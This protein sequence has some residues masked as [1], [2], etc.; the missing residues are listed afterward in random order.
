MSTATPLEFNVFIAVWR[1]PFE[2]GPCAKIFTK[3][4]FSPLLNGGIGI[5][6][7]LSKV[8]LL[9]AICWIVLVAEGSIEE[10]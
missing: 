10:V 3:R 5:S 6:F 7:G 4:T 2:N 8:M 1:F 9:S